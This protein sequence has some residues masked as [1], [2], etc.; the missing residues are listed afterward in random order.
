MRRTV[1]GSATK[2]CPSDFRGR[3][4]ISASMLWISR[5]VYVISGGRP[6]SR[7]WRAAHGP[8]RLPSLLVERVRHRVLIDGSGGRRVDADETGQRRRRPRNGIP[9][10][11]HELVRTAVGTA[12]ARPRGSCCLT[13]TCAGDATSRR[14]YRPAS[15][16]PGLP[17]ERAL[18]SSSVPWS[19]ARSSSAWPW[20]SEP[21]SSSVP[22]SSA[23]SWWAP[24]WWAAWWSPPSSSAPSWS[25]AREWWSVVVV[26]AAQP[27]RRPPL[28]LA[29]LGIA[30]RP[31]R[32]EIAPRRGTVREQ[33]VTTRGR[34]SG[35]VDLLGAGCCVRLTG[36]N[37]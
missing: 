12:R 7:Q 1:F 35:R 2:F 18:R 32:A 19:S 8:G 37:P 20:S 6:P 24:S 34:V 11:L 25:S 5:R 4:P 16:E 26:V 36:L 9:R 30:L 27:Q 14:W 17:A 3:T 31:R 21:W 22:W 33:R 23:R 10:R 28:P 29:P 15:P 13:R